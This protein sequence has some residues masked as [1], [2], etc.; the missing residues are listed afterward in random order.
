MMVGA[1]VLPAMIDGMIEASTTRSPPIPCTRSRGS[2]TAFGPW[3]MPQLPT[4]CR[5]DTPRRRTSAASCSSVA[6]DRPRQHLLHHEPLQRR[7]AGDL[8]RDANAGDDRLHVVIAAQEVE[9]DLRRRQR[10]GALQPHRAASLRA[11]MHRTDR[12]SRE[13]MRDDAL[14]RA[15]DRAPGGDVHLQVRP[16]QRWIAA[17][18]RADI[19]PVARHRT[20]APEQVFRAGIQAGAG[21]C[22]AAR[23]ATASAR[24]ARRNRC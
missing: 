1:L 13:R 15:V 8:A 7:L 20:A 4:G 24:C 16:L 11:Q 18:Q 14:A 3:P 23:S 19:E 12:E 10:I 21:C 17:H 6:T 2:T 22:D 5:L 9:A